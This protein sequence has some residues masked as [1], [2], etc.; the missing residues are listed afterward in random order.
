MHRGQAD[1]GQGHDDEVEDEPEVASEEPEPV[2][3]EV[4]CELGGED[5][6]EDEVGTV[7]VREHLRHRR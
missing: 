6:L 7:Q 4:C 5:E 1:E 2:C 3:V